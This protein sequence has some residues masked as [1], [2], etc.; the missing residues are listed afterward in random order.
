MH[1]FD[2]GLTIALILSGVW[3]CFRGLVREVLSLVGLAAASVLALRGAA[4]L[5][6]M[7]TKI[8]S[9]PWLGHAISFALI[10]LVVMAVAMLCARAIRLMLTA[11][12]LS[13]LDRLLGGVFGVAKVVL[14][15]TVLLMLANK[16]VP[17]LRP[18]LEA[19]AALAPWMYQNVER[20]ATFLDQHDEL[21][22]HLQPPR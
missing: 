5:A 21:V 17:T 22:Q 13:P 8:T 1:W 9:I 20:L 14:G 6:P 12:G 11:V 18:E 2:I 15:A 3:S 7:L 4:Y 10:F 19:N 16:Y